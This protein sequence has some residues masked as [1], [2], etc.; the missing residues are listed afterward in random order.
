M[1]V[2][3]CGSAKNSWSWQMLAQLGDMQC[4]YLL[5]YLLLNGTS[6]PKQYCFP[7]MLCKQTCTPSF[8]FFRPFV[9]GVLALWDYTFEI[10]MDVFICWGYRN[11]SQTLHVRSVCLRC[12]NKLKAQ[13]AEEHTIMPCRTH[14]LPQMLGSI[15]VHVNVSDVMWVIITIPWTTHMFDV[16]YHLQKW[17]FSWGWFLT[18]LYPY[19]FVKSQ[20]ISI[21]T[22]DWSFGRADFFQLWNGVGTMPWLHCCW[23]EDPWSMYCMCCPMPQ[24]SVLQQLVA[25]WRVQWKIAEQWQQCIMGH[26]GIH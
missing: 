19:T 10:W 9:G 25:P 18:L 20:Q 14:R 17:R 11:V 24:Y 1:V 22:T 3:E 16:L 8:H 15:K 2:S 7:R 13:R 4:S 23:V 12:R 5:E 6:L 26:G 21:A